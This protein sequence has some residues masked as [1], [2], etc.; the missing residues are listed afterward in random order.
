[1]L[2]VLTKVLLKTQTC[3]LDVGEC[4]SSI[5]YQNGKFEKLSLIPDSV[6]KLKPHMLFASKLFVFS[7][8]R[9]YI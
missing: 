8:L 4:G 3:K 5:Y 7:H 2:F 6:N 9:D 1:M